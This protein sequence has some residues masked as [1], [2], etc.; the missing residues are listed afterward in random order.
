M[1]F[2]TFEGSVFSNQARTSSRDVR[3]R[4]PRT[5]PKVSIYTKK[6]RKTMPDEMDDDHKPADSRPAE[7]P[8]QREF[9]QRPLIPDRPEHSAGWDAEPEHSGSSWSGERWS[10]RN[11]SGG[12]DR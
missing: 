4:R 9:F 7:L 11:Q 10:G 1:I 6:G 3:R 8:K 2:A 12:R 5:E